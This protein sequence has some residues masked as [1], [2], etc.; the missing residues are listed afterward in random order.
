MKLLILFLLLFMLLY[1]CNKPADENEQVLKQALRCIVLPEE[2]AVSKNH[3]ISFRSTQTKAIE[4]LSFCACNKMNTDICLLA[5]MSLHSGIKRFV[6]WDFI[7]Y[8][9][10][11]SFLVGHGCCD[12]PWYTELSK[13][14]P[15]FS[16]LPESHCSSL[17][18]YKI[19]NRAYS[20]WG[21]NVKYILHGLE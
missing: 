11:Y 10:I 4:A 5:D 17:G 6:V 14:S 3:C 19:G 13:D 20:D 18:K 12:N 21:I 15:Q 8:T 1:A 9:I 16:N 2:K 7:K